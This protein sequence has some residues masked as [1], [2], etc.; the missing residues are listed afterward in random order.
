MDGDNMNHGNGHDGHD[1]DDD[2]Q[3]W[4]ERITQEPDGKLD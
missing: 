4:N 1:G 2:G 3:K